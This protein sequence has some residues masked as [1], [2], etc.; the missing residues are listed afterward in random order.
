MDHVEAG[1][2]VNRRPRECCLESRLQVFGQRLGT[3]VGLGLKE[4]AYEFC[5]ASIG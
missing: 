4:G 5:D 3:F 2:A 1:L